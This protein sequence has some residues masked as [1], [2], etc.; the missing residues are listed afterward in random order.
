MASREEVRSAEGMG[1]HTMVR[2]VDAAAS[3]LV[4]P[5]LSAPAAAPEPPAVQP[6]KAPN[7]PAIA[8]AALPATNWRLLKNPS[9]I[10]AFLIPGAIAGIA[11]VFGTS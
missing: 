2:I 9:A 5:K 11:F 10:V 7:M 4:R 6:V 1:S 8:S 3:P